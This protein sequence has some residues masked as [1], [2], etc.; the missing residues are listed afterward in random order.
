[1]RDAAVT[2]TWEGSFRIVGATTDPDRNLAWTNR[3][4]GVLTDSTGA[5]RICGVPR[6]LPV[7]IR[8]S[9]E[10][11]TDARRVRLG[12]DDPIASFDLAL[13]RAPPPADRQFPDSMVAVVEVSVTNGDGAPLP[14]V[15]LDLEVPGVGPR[16][17]TTGM[18][19]RALV[20]DARAGRIVVTARRIGFL[21]G[22]VSAVV[23]PG[24]NTVPIVL[25]EARLPALDTVRIVGDRR[26]FGHDRLDEFEDR[27]LNKLA[28]RTITRD[29]IAR[30]NPTAAWQML[31][32]VPALRISDRGDGMVVATMTRAM[33][34]NLSN[35]PCYPR[36]M[37][38]GVLVQE[39]A[40]PP[41]FGKAATATPEGPGTPRPT[42]LSRLPPPDAIYGIEVFAGPASIPLQYGGSGNG[43]WCGL[44]AIWTR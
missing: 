14:N 41:V 36:V 23:A 31:T 4:V 28:T 8:A 2:A 24:R 13:H 6:E 30:R 7:V 35:A 26:V 37:V 10:L 40:P 5:W 25:G 34:Q 11:M 18:T 9:R 1:V 42:D 21:P 33:I 22:K 29:E 39:D 32:N 16:T 12:A 44:I 17:V 15:R 3:S 38:D 27:R 19:G 43:K 20:A